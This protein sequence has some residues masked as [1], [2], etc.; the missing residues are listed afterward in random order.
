MV[1]RAFTL[2]E[3]L[4]VVAIIAI[5][6]AIAVPNFLEAQTRAKIVDVMSTQRTVDTA[7]SI[8][9]VDTNKV[10]PGDMH[11]ALFRVTSPISYLSRVPPASS[12]DKLDPWYGEATPWGR[13]LIN[14][15]GYIPTRM[16]NRVWYAEAFGVAA[17]RPQPTNFV[18]LSETT[19]LQ[20]SPSGQFFQ[21]S[22]GP[23]GGNA[24]EQREGPGY[25]LAWTPYDPSNGTISQGLIMRLDGGVV[26]GGR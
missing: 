16:Y 11:A 20:E 15:Y 14:Q 3:L 13:A 12:F 26:T 7:V 17:G 6:A 19:F 5:L 24:W 9:R 2:I 23:Y 1:S 10:P 8:Y 4:I 22:Q 21:Y 25:G 18:W